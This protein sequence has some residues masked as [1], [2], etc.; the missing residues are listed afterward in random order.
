MAYNDPIIDPGFP[1]EEIQGIWIAMG[2]DE[3]CGGKVPME[4]T[5]TSV[6]GQEGWKRNWLI[7]AVSKQ[8]APGNTEE[9]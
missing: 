8:S 4:S 1:W 7:S 5:E 2:T 9:Q 6:A 3:A